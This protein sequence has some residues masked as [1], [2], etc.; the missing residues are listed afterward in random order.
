M[1]IN[2][3]PIII[4]AYLKASLLELE[5]IS[6]RTYKRA[7]LSDLK[8]YSSETTALCGHIVEAA[9]LS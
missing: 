7:I 4:A 3:C 1:Q 9:C 6:E 2:K 5:E 8:M